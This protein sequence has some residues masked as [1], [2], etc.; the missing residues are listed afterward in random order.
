MDAG[1]RYEICKLTK[2]KLKI[3]QGSHLRKSFCNIAACVI[4]YI[5]Y[6]DVLSV[7]LLNRKKAKQRRQ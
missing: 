6:N 3:D 7:N 5:P 4:G 1:N 2:E